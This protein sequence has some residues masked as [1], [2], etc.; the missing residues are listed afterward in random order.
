[1]CNF[2][3][4]DDHSA[5]CPFIYYRLP[6]W[7]M[8]HSIL[9]CLITCMTFIIKSCIKRTEKLFFSVDP[10]SVNDKLSY[11]VGRK[12]LY[13]AKFW[14]FKVEFEQRMTCQYFEIEVL[15]WFY[16]SLELYK[17][18]SSICSFDLVND[19]KVLLYRLGWVV[20]FN[21]VQSIKCPIEHMLMPHM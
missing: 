12:V 1:M 9:R 7:R 13:F 14:Q 20:F 2:L 4:A 16:N 18:I 5:T 15:T 10:K 8:L 17:I 11:S 21:F 6:V 19:F 3:L